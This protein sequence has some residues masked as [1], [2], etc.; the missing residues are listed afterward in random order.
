[1]IAEPVL[2]LHSTSLVGAQEYFTESICVDQWR[3]FED[4]SCSGETKKCILLRAALVALGVVDNATHRYQLVV[5]RSIGIWLIF[6][7]VVNFPCTF[8]VNLPGTVEFPCQS[9]STTPL[10]GASA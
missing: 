2:E 1:M 5:S 8:H 3:D 6:F 4:L 10:E 7:F 9:I